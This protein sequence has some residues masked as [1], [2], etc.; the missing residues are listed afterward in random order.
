M[1]VDDFV[2]MNRKRLSVTALCEAISLRRST[3]YA[4]RKKPG[5]ARA[6]RDTD[7][8]GEIALVRRG[9]SKNIGRRNVAH[10]LRRKGKPAGEKRI[11]RVMKANGWYGVPHS[12]RSRPALPVPISHRDL[13]QRKF[14]AEAPNLLWWGDTKEFWTG[15]GKLYLAS[16]Q[17]AYSRYIVGFALSAT[18]DSELTKAALARAVRSRRPQRGLIHHTDRGGPYT[19]WSYQTQVERIGARPS[20]SRPGV[21]HDNAC[22][23]SFHSTLQ[24]EFLAFNRFATRSQ[25]TSQISGWIRNYNL[26]RFHSTLGYLSPAEHESHNAA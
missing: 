15:E 9:Y 7:L 25:A 21:P 1:T 11:G 18:N 13:V 10:A 12:R 16:L 26:K 17:D 3:Y 22:I 6:K 8:A 24:R 5:S 20:V 19:S 23:E 14:S 2:D 4:R